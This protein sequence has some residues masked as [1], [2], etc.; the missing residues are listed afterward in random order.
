[1]SRN[2][3]KPRLRDRLRRVA[4]AVA[5]PLWTV[6]S[7]FFIGQ[8]IVVVV[9]LGSLVQIQF[10]DT[11]TEGGVFLALVS[12]LTYCIGLAILLIEPY[13]I[14]N[15]T[16]R[17]MRELLGL[18]RRPM[19]DDAVKAVLGWAGYFMAIA[20]VANVVM[21]LLPQF[22]SDQIQE[23]GFNTGGDVTEK[24]SAFVVVVIAAPIVEEIVFR[25]YLQGSLRR[26]MPWWLGGVITS[27]AFGVVHGQ[28][29]VGIDVF[30]LSMVACY[31]RE[32]T[33]AIWAGIGLHMIKN[34]IAYYILFWAPPWLVSLLGGP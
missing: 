33:G 8:S 30:I 10:D 20:L 29:N 1:M 25:G 21:W 9:M 31:L 2:S 34:S 18:V 26:F 6:G 12:V 23:I 27:V 32:R 5:L 28:W 19:I 22:N 14:R 11:Q 16:R 4:A 7:V 13:A 15:M 24:I 17:Q 3:S